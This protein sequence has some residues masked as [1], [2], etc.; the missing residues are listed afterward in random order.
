M[1]GPEVHKQ[2]LTVFD[3]GGFAVSLRPCGGAPQVARVHRL[4]HLEVRAGSPS[5]WEVHRN[6]N[7][8]GE[9]PS[10]L[11]SRFMGEAVAKTIPQALGYIRVPKAFQFVLDIFLKPV[12][13]RVC[14]DSTHARA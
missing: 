8:Q 1:G 6:S 4:L 11:K 5:R 7:V 9:L 10:V 13:W 14:R 12:A 2:S 3:S